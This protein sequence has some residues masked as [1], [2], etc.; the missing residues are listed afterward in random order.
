MA[1]A[2]VLK[3]NLTTPE[4][5]LAVMDAYD[6]RKNTIIANVQSGMGVKE[7]DLLMLRPTGYA[8]EFELKLTKGDLMK[9]FN[10]T[11]GHVSELIKETFFVMPMNVVSTAIQVLP[12]NFGV[13]G[14]KRDKDFNP[15]MEQI[16]DAQSNPNARKW[17]DEERMQ[18]LR[19]GCMRLYKLKKDL[20]KCRRASGQ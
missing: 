6:I 16:R 10:K 15:V 5:E 12:K 7:C 13:I 1:V 2:K 8:T 4:L 3:G 18:F 17:T 11:D 20:V 19:L 14:V 9:D